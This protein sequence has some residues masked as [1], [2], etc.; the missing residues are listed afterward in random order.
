M[1]KIC[2]PGTKHLRSLA[3][4]AQRWAELRDLGERVWLLHPPANDR[5]KALAAYLARG[6][7]QAVHEAYK[8][9]IRSPWWR[10]PAVSPPDLF[11]TYMSHR[12]PRL[13]ANT[14]GATFVNSMH[15]VRLLPDAPRIARSALPLVSLNSVSLLGAE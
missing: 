10:P 8:C 12:Y 7:E 4:S 2:P 9:T 3:F 15:G 6:R 1:I 14:A 11:F 5:S 13:I